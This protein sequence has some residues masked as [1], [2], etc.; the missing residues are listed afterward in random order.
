ML[1]L[2]RNVT[3]SLYIG[4]NIKI[5]ICGVSGNQV[6]VG[7]EAPKEVP[8]LREEIRDQYQNKQN[9]KD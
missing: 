9:G 5:T 3:Q 1:L 7:I 6:K 4:D 2:T 8:I